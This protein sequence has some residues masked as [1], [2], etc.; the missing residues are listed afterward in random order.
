[1]PVFKLSSTDKIFKRKIILIFLLR[2]V[3]VKDPFR[4]AAQQELLI[5][6]GIIIS[7]GFF[8]PLSIMAHS[9]MFALSAVTQVNAPQEFYSTGLV[10][11]L[12][13][14]DIH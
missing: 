9:I 3:I 5:Y 7:L 1:M 12:V 10:I 4:T 11:N 6:N 14:M 8:F 13:R 2:T